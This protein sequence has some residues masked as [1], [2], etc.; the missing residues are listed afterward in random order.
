MSMDNLQRNDVTA[1]AAAHEEGRFLS[2]GTYVRM[3]GSGPAAIFVHGLGLD[4]TV[5]S[6]Q[7]AA[8]SDRMTIVTYDLVGHGSSSKP[9]I[10]HCVDLY[11]SQ[12]LTVM[13]EL[14]LSTATVVGFSLGGLIVRGFALAY[15]QRLAGLGIMNTWFQRTPAETKRVADRMAAAAAAGPAASVDP[16]LI[17][18]FSDDFRARSPEVL[19]RIARMLKGNDP[20]SYI[21]A[22][23]VAVEPGAPAV[24]E[25]ERIACPSLVMTCDEDRGNSP[26]MAMRLSENIPDCE[27][28]IL[29]GLR[30]MAL[31][32][33]ASLV[34]AALE[35]LFRRADNALTGP[36]PAA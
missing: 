18:W 19:D 21:S 5:W 36:P 17:R 7:E 33:N 9:Q 23:R 4:H 30:H 3:V 25:V 6:H 12:L 27:L 31:I 26:G 29:P 20:Q 16:A 24:D 28:V 1:A 11:V 8:F 32:E 35:R 14:E 13:D 22:Y 34:N 2:D 10:E 15:P